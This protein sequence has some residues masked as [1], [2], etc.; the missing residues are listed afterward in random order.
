MMNTRQ[1]GEMRQVFDLTFSHIGH[2]GHGYRAHLVHPTT[3]Q[4]ACGKQG[5]NDYEAISLDQITCHV[6]LRRAERHQYDPV[7]VPV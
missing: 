2:V 6:C 1:E 5:V 3:G 4:T 7:E